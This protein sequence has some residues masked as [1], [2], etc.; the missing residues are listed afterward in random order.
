MAR[1]FHDFI[2]LG[3]QC[4]RF[5]AFVWKSLNPNYAASSAIHHHRANRIS[6]DN[7]SAVCPMA[8]SCADWAQ[9]PDL[10]APDH[11]A[12]ERSRLAADRQ[13]ARPHRQSCA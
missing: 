6:H 11:T 3:L 10:T 7:R 1:P 5:S 8:K 9:A 4:G 13:S 12:D 2:N